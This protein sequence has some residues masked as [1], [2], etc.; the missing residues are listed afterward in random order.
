MTNQD[1]TEFFR[2]ATQDLDDA[3]R[4][5]SENGLSGSP[6][7]RLQQIQ[8]KCSELFQEFRR[9]DPDMEARDL[10]ALTSFLSQ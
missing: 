8:S 5:A 2:A 6:M 10:S 3:V 4:L 9:L 1:A 7:N